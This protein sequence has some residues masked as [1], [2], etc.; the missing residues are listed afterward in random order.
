MRRTGFLHGATFFHEATLQDP[1]VI[2]NDLVD[3]YGPGL[4]AGQLDEVDALYVSS[5]LH[6]SVLE[7][8]TPHVLEFLDRPDTRVYIDGVNRVGEWLPGTTETV[9]GT[10][11]WAW[12]VGEDVGRRSRNQDHPVWR[13]LSER[14]VHWHYHGVLDHPEAA[15][16]LVSL[17]PVANPP[18][19]VD[20]WGLGYR[21]L[22]GHPNTVLYFDD[23]TFASE[24]IV[25]TM[26]ASYHHGSGFMP[27]AT[28]LM[29][30]MMRWLAEPAA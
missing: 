13:Y 19:E 29:Y 2:A 9:R 4:S 8:V 1:A 24:L 28:Q 26:D 7:R 25:S 14:S 18:Q 10:N 16:P 21:A 30:R 11:F 3:L 22:P 5:R 27:G 23:A 20:P 12:R 15:V 6:E 17:E